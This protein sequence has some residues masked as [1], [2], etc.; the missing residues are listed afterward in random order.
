M[1]TQTIARNPLSWF[2][3]LGLT[4]SGFLI[5]LIYYKPAATAEGDWI[6]YLPAANSCFNALCAGC[7]IGGFVNIKRG[8]R[9][10]HMRC[11]LAALVFS[12]LFLGSYIVYHHFHG[13]TSFPG[14]GPIRLVYFFILISHI[15][16]SIVALPLVFTT[17]YHAARGQFGAHKRIARY[18]FPI[19]LYVS[20][21]G[22]LVFFFL[23]AYI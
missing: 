21:T 4:I 7:L 8:N 19:W 13:D 9:D 17:L 15:V 5:W 3:L 14:Q 16:L 22:V 1:T 12:V 10:V 11:M 6:T 18:T 20:V 23:R 2:F